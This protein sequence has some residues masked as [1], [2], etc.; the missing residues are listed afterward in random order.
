MRLIGD[1]DPGDAI[2]IAHVSDIHGGLDINRETGVVAS[3]REC[4]KVLDRFGVSVV[5]VTGDIADTPGK[6]RAGLEVLETL[7]GDSGKRK[8]R[9]VLGNHDRWWK[10]IGV[11]VW[12]R[13]A[14]ASTRVE[15]TIR[16]FHL[17]KL[18]TV[19]LGAEEDFK[20]GLVGLDS[21]ERAK[22]VA[23]GY[24]SAT[25]LDHLLEDANEASAT[26]CDLVLGLVHHH[27]FKVADV[28]ARGAGLEEAALTFVNSARFM[29]HVSVSEIN[30]LLHGHRHA[31]NLC[32]YG[33]WDR[34]RVHVLGAGSLSG[35]GKTSCTPA[36]RAFTLL[37]IDTAGAVDAFFLK[38]TERPGN[39]EY[40]RYEIYQ[41]GRLDRHRY[42]RQ[43]R[44]DRNS[45]CGTREIHAV[46][47]QDGDGH[48]TARKDDVPNCGPVE[49]TAS[50]S[51]GKPVA[52]SFV[53]AGDR[54]DAQ[55]VRTNPGEWKLSGSAGEGAPERVAA[56]AVYHFPRV[57]CVSKAEL[58]LVR[59]AGTA[60]DDPHRAQG[61]E[62]VGLRVEQPYRRITISV[63]FVSAPE[64]AGIATRVTALPGS[65]T[66]PRWMTRAFTWKA[67]GSG[68]ILAEVAYPRPGYR[69]S[70]Q[71]R[72]P[73][74]ALDTAEPVIAELRAKRSQIQRL[75]RELEQDV[76]R[77]LE[78]EGLSLDFYHLD[79]GTPVCLRSLLDEQRVHPIVPGEPGWLDSPLAAAWRR[80]VPTSG[81]YDRTYFQPFYLPTPTAPAG[82]I[83]ATLRPDTDWERRQFEYIAGIA[84]KDV[85]EAT[86]ELLR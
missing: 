82:V 39:W 73:G 52:K 23:Q 29:E 83:A 10:G 84:C 72:P 32:V 31:R 56:E 67:V 7:A 78:D 28:E 50:N 61:W 13:I 74:P 79:L 45:V 47:N 17:G 48:W 71:W 77:A 54:P 15:S 21:A 59:V 36:D 64:A 3:V 53:L 6:A 81:R 30:V 2:W 19:T 25:P 12:R 9:A 18:E 44:L 43:A 1:V 5:L 8:V 63:S 27:P 80:S 75:L 33:A 38:W 57:V 76:A 69:Y 70:V 11:P 62:G 51:W 26:E 22:W 4:C 58:D 65:P 20:L 37:R 41:Q 40:E 49:F 55:F 16:R 86:L 24:L 85:F 35:A 14:G 60:G 66:A 42:E 68:V 34:P 46:F